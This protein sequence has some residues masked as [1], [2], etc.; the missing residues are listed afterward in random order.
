MHY[1]PERVVLLIFNSFTMTQPISL[2]IVD[3]EMDNIRLISR[4]LGSYQSQISIMGKYTEPLKA[5]DD[6]SRDV[7]DVILLDIEMPLM[8]G[9]DLLDRLD[10]DKLEVVFITGHDQYA[11]Q[12]IKCAAID[13]ILKPFSCLELHQALNKVKDKIGNRGIRIE[14][15]KETL[16]GKPEKQMVVPGTSAYLALTYDNILYLKAIRGGYTMFHMVN[17]KKSLATNPLSFYENLL[18]NHGF[19][20]THKSHLVN[21]RYVDA[22]EPNLLLTRM[23]DG[24]ELELATRRKTSFLKIWR[25]AS[26]KD[27]PWD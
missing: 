4:Y 11:V 22:Y 25:D 7:P 21:L 6:L 1:T 3:D 12:A 17:G 26:G 15:I 18:G 5:Y 10:S 8:N 16:S 2:A 14:S 13:Y 27:N 20:R 9:F 19:Y 24:T 23:V